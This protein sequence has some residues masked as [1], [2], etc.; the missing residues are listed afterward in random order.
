[1]GW[2]ATRRWSRR[3]DGARRG[4]SHARQHADP[5]QDG[6]I[7]RRA[8]QHHRH[9]PPRRRG[10]RPRAQ[11]HG[12]D[13]HLEIRAA[14]IAQARSAVRTATSR[15]LPLSPPRHGSAV[16]IA[17]ST[18]SPALRATAREETARLASHRRGAPRGARRAQRTGLIDGPLGCAAMAEF[19]PLDGSAPRKQQFS[20]PP[21]LGIDPNK[22]Y[23]ATLD[24]SLGEIVIALDA[25]E[26]A[27]D[28][29][30]LR[31]P[32][33]P[34]LLRRR[35]LPPHHQRLHVPGRR[36]DRHRPRRP[37]LPVRRRA[38]EGRAVPDRLR[39]DGQRR[40]E[41]QRQPVLPHLRHRRRRA[42]RRST[43]CSVR[44]SRVSTS[45]DTMQRVAT[46]A[47][48]PARRGRRHQLGHDHRIAD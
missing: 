41:H 2:A 39:G 24:T 48:R 26:G 14:E 22:R 5:H 37:R 13:R 21:D 34:P 31:V 36:P 46:G 33:P 20:S 11:A 3:R 6:A 32:R 27:E 15:T 16:R 40:S 42:C 44:S 4:G 47:R 38:A 19:P 12:A 35:H 9:R 25:A 18:T 1:M 45:L 17:T 43:A 10:C 29:Q 8:R 28:G 23:T 7:D 30:Q